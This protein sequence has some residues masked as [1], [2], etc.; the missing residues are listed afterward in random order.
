MNESQVKPFGS[1][2]RISSHGG[3]YRGRW[4]Q[5]VCHCGQ[6]MLVPKGK[7]GHYQ[8]NTCADRAEGLG[9]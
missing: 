2:E 5:D 8:C 4:E 6:R 3:W 7:K 9:Y 1:P